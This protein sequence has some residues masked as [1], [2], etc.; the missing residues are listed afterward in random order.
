MDEWDE[1]DYIYAS[2]TLHTREYYD[3]KYQSNDA[4]TKMYK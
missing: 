1:E 4:Y 2:S 3:L